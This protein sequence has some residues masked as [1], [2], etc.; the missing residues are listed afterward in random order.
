M[1]TVDKSQNYSIY[2]EN[3]FYF[4]QNVALVAGGQFL[5]AIRDRNDRFLTDGDQSGRRAYSIFSPRGGL[6][7]TLLLMYRS[8]PISHAVRKYRPSTRIHS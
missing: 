5:H 1:S 6:L 4:L 8:L 3:S 2:A 7:G